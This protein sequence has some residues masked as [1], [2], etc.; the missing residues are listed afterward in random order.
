MIVRAPLPDEPLKA[1]VSR[2]KRHNVC[3]SDTELFG[4]L[5]ACMSIEVG[6]P[7][8]INPIEFLAEV[9]GV[10]PLFLMR[11]HTMLPFTKFVQ[12]F[13]RGGGEVADLSNHKYVRSA[14]RS[15]QN[16]AYLCPKCVAEDLDFTGITYW[17]RVHQLPGVDWCS[18]HDVALHRCEE[19]DAFERSPMFMLD[20]SSALDIEQVAKARDHQL[21]GRYARIAEG[22]LAEVTQPFHIADVSI[23]IRDW[24]KEQDLRVSINGKRPLLS[25]RVADFF[26]ETW[27][28]SHFPLSVRK[29]AGVFS[30]WVDGTWFS[31][32][33]PC[34]TALYVLALALMYESSDDALNALASL[35]P[36]SIPRKAE[37]HR[38]P[39]AWDTTE[40]VE[41]WMK[42]LGN[43][44]AIAEDLGLSNYYVRLRLNEA[45]LPTL[46]RSAGEAV[47][48][49]MH[50]FW[51]GESFSTVGES[52]GADQADLDS[53]LRVATERYLASL[54]AK[55]SGPAS[56]NCEALRPLARR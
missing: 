19:S 36:V 6:E 28:A 53:F 40:I 23:L 27:L 20:S 38:M 13:D 56:T 15:P 11:Q 29:E 14:W 37:V 47:K 2:M 54:W 8:K 48:G 33:T 42:H 26:P 46:R 31:R 9:Y 50:N 7:S 4:R 52:V 24:A 3:S 25:D 21:I 35:T 16:H 18:R 39:G 43:C 30:S 44:S 45:G 41:V 51:R 12:W 5:A 17:R 49:A 55:S 1:F 34:S 22:L 10:K 32:K